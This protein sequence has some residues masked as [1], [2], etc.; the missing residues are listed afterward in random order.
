VKPSA[1]QAVCCPLPI[2]IRI[3]SKAVLLRHRGEQETTHRLGRKDATNWGRQLRDWLWRGKA[4]AALQSGPSQSQRNASATGRDLAADANRY[5]GL[6][7]RSI[8]LI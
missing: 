2:G 4:V 3:W 1:E 5:A 8:C 6:A 7:V